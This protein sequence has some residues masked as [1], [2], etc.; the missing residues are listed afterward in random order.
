MF[1]EGTGFASL[2]NSRGLFALC[3][4]FDL[5]EFIFLSSVPLELALPFPSPFPELEL[6]AAAGPRM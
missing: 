2:E 3:G 1:A 4:V 5:D 6:A